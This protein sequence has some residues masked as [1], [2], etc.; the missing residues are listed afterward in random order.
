MKLSSGNLTYIATEH[1][2]LSWIYPL[3]YH[4]AFPVR[5]VHG[6]YIFMIL[7]RSPAKRSHDRF[8]WNRHLCDSVLLSN[9]WLFHMRVGCRAV[10]TRLSWITPRWEAVCTGLLTTILRRQVQDG[11]GVVAV[12][13][14]IQMDVISCQNIALCSTLFHF[15]C[16]CS[17]MSQVVL[18]LK[19]P[20]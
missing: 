9:T 15:L 5:Y 2:H 6:G 19:L 18:V 16:D 12:V 8:S 7:Q 13:W 1:D 20:A 4:G 11:V 10:Q 17:S 3:I 14:H